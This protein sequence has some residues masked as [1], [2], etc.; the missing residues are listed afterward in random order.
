MLIKKKKWNV[1]FFLFQAEDGIRDFHVTGVQTCALPIS[2]VAEDH[3]EPAELLRLDA[4]E[5]DRESLATSLLLEIHADVEG[6]DP[7]EDDT[8]FVAPFDDVRVDEPTRDHQAAER[9]RLLV[10][11]PAAEDRLE[12]AHELEAP[13]RLRRALEAGPR[14]RVPE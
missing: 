1:V 10:G 12:A 8:E 14:R 4:L 9:Q 6:V 3:L 5:R 2:S 7:T 13:T 11:L